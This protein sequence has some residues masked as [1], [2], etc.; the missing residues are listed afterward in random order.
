MRKAIETVF[1][2]YRFRSELVARWAV[3]LDALDTSFVCEKEKFN[4]AGVPFFPDFWVEEWNCWIAIRYG[5]PTDDEKDKCERLAIHTDKEV[6]LI[7]GIP[8][9]ER[10]TIMYFDT[11]NGFRSTQGSDGWEFAEGRRCREEIWLFS[12]G[13]GALTL[14]TIPHDDGEKWPLSGESAR[15]I[16]AALE[17]AQDA[18]FCIVKYLKTKT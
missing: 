10:Y 18:E 5:E 3:F 7:S 1:K 17:A 12:D 2:D 15:S 11:P 16:L 9:L 4:L 14:K 6:L 13:R 8:Q